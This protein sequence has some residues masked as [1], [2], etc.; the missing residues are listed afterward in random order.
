MTGIQLVTYLR[1]CS[2]KCKNG[3][4]EQGGQITCQYCCIGDRFNYILQFILIPDKFLFKKIL[5]KKSNV[6]ELN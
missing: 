1:G 5:R 2:E 6:F 4:G 3:C